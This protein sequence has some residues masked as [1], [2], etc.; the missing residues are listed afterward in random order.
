MDPLVAAQD[1]GKP[2]LSKLLAVPSLR[3]KYLGY[4]R[5]IANQWLDWE[6]L[7]PLA[8]QYHALIEAEVHADTR[9]LDSNEAF[10]QSLEAAPAAAPAADAGE[11]GFGPGRGPRLS[12]KAF[13]EQRRAFLLAH[14]EV[15]KLAP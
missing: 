8:R 11:P 14:P 5:E 6:K 2:L 13:A 7:G 10:D 4:V 1:E 12:L 3:T 15:K 9:K